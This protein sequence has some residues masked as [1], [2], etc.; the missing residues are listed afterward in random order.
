MRPITW[1]LILTV[2]SGLCW[3]IFSVIVGFIGHAAGLAAAGAKGASS[4]PTPVTLGLVY[5][6]GLIFFFSVP[7]TVGIEVWNWYK[8][9]KEQKR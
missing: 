2:I 8:R 9:R 3:L 4:T 1:G 5:F 6:F 7:V